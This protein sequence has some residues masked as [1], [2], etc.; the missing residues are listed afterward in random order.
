MY[1]LGM[2][3]I[4]GSKLL[5]LRFG[6]SGVFQPDQA[7][8]HGDRRARFIRI[9]DGTA[10]IRHGGD[11]QQVAVPVETLSLPPASSV[12]RDLPLFNRRIPTPPRRDTRPHPSRRTERPTYF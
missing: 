4:A 7:V 3:T 5:Q 1:T 2:D 10:I 12:R 8:M 9:S 11:S 6:P